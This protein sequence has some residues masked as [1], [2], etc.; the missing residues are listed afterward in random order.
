[1]TR[2]ILLPVGWILLLLGAVGV[3]IPVWP[4]T[5]FVLLASGCFA[6]GSPK[7]SEKLANSRFFGEFI[8][9]YREKTGV[10][11]KTKA[12][13]IGFLWLSLGV[14]MVLCGVL[15]VQLLL[16]AIGIAVTAHIALLRGKH[17]S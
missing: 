12:I 4:T 14:S 17:R 9:N 10:A 13:S 3:L 8:R 6:A 7:F 16:V 5:P 11:M 15:W 2:L 1:M